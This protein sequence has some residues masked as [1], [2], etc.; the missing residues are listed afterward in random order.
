MSDDDYTPDTAPA[1]RQNYAENPRP[2]TFDARPDLPDDQLK[3]ADGHRSGGGAAGAQPM[4]G[5]AAPHLWASRQRDP[6][7]VAPAPRT[8]LGTLRSALELAGRLRPRTERRRPFG[9]AP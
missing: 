5:L 7:Y 1:N 6:A 2:S 8:T 3:P 4:G 9:L